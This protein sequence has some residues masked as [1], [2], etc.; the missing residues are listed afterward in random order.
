MTLSSITRR[1]ALLAA[2][3]L[4]VAPMFTAGQATARGGPDPWRPKRKGKKTSGG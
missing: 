1:A 2:I 4:G 3:G